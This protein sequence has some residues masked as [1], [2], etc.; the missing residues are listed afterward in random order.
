MNIPLIHIQ[1]FFKYKA[2]SKKLYQNC[3]VDQNSVL[4]K[5]LFVSLLYPYIEI[6]KLPKLAVISLSFLGLTTISSYCWYLW[7]LSV[8]DWRLQSSESCQEHLPNTSR[9]LGLLTKT[10]ADISIGLYFS[11]YINWGS[12]EGFLEQAFTCSMQNHEA[13]G[14]G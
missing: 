8:F 5:K 3:S 4:Y 1:K 14:Y 6:M 7:L 9:P 11:Q 13:K 10:P 2:I 12:G